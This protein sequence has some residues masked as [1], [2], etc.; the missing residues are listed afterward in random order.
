MNIELNTQRE[1]ENAVGVRQCA[2]FSL[3]PP[4]CEA[5]R[6]KR[7]RSERRPFSTLNHFSGSE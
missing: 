5:A 1:R 4:L 7:D 2:A 6:N 3:G